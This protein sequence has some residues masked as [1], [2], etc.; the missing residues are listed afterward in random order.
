[1]LFLGL[2][3]SSCNDKVKVEKKLPKY[4][5]W[6]GD[7]AG[8]DWAET[9][10]DLNDIGIGGI[11]VGGSAD[12]YKKVAPLCDQYNIELHAWQVIMM[13]DAKTAEQHPEWLSVN[14]LGHSLADSMAY[15]PYYRFMSPILP[16]V[17]ANILEKVN[18]IIAVEGVKGLSLDY[19][20]YVDAILPENLWSIYN[21]VQDKVY[22]QWDYGYHP[23]MIDAFQQMH[24]YSPL[25]LEE[26]S[27]DT[28]WNRFRYDQVNAIANEIAKMGHDAGKLI[29]ASP[30][31]TPALARKHVLQDWE[32]WDMDIVFPMVY[33]GMYAEEG[34]EW[35]RSCVAENISTMSPKGCT[36]Y[37]GLYVPGHRNTDFDIVEAMKTAL[38]AGSE[39]ISF[40]DY[41]T[42]TPEEKKRIKQFI[43]ENP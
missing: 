39:G 30:F 5:C 4:W 38:D 36:V 19:T 18:K 32:N 23:A 25:D 16:E 6:I 29:S 22:P 41:H 28:L 8:L 20:R 15:V 42:L 33:N 11:L 34:N 43:L 17:R 35:V 3:L 1:L 21:I 26:P 7:R 31:P 2:I 9:M 40:F 37:T 14:R 24:G 27:A 10:V 13:A 12:T